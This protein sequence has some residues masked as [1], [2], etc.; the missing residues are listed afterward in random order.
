ME[1]GSCTWGSVG[2]TISISVTYVIFCM[3]S[4]PENTFR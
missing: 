1:L 2:V 4:P 3:S